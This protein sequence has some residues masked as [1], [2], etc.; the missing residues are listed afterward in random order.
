VL[1]LY[2]DEDGCLWIGTDGGGLNRFKDGKFTRYTRREGLFD[3]VQY[4]ILEDGRGNLWMSC[5]RGIYR[6]ARSELE[7]LAR[8]ERTSVTSIAFGRADGMR[9][10][11]CSGFTQ[12]A[13][14]KARDGRLWFPTVEGAVVIDPDR[15][16][17]N[18][19]PPPVAIERVLVDRRAVEAPEGARIP[20]AHGDL[21]F[22]Y[23]GLS[24]V[25]PGRVNFRYRLEGFD[26]EWI[27]AG[28]R[29]VAFYTNIPPGSY[30]FRV[31][32][33]NND[34]VWNE[35]GASVSFALR[36]HFY[37]T[38]GFLALSGIAAILTALG[39]GRFRAL[40]IRDR[41]RELE[42]QVAERTLELEHLNER[43]QQLSALDPLTGIANRRRF[44]ETLDAEW[45][46]GVRDRLPLS[47]V[48]IDIDHFKDFNDAFGHQTGDDCLRRVAG[49][50]RHA[51]TRP[52]DLVSRFGGEEF[53]AVLPST[54]ARGA[55]AVAEALRARIEGMGA[56]HPRSPKGVVTIS[57]GVATVV[58][59]AAASADTLIAAADRA[60]YAAK[61]GGRNRV[62]TAEAVPIALP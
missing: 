44:G 1:S 58:P 13:A 28:T 16:Q 27:E 25:D 57:L 12:P 15:I 56:R 54:P 59:D 47:L 40:R 55:A 42:Q 60:L 41:E 20:P 19:I 4:G 51:L 34:G 61:R 43:L 46:R 45:R 36:P 6:V 10:A 23:A 32:A 38:R 52:G 17:T 33:C 48:M 9:S 29:R 8:G 39:L 53:A 11:E 37:Q 2:E 18:P 24:F 7:A 22:H 35:K 3:D 50:I 5:S 31:L 62:E 14:W 21:E 26:R 30:R 49:E